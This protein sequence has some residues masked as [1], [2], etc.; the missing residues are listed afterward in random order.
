MK[1]A[2]ITPYLHSHASP[3]AAAGATNR[4]EQVLR[5]AS[6]Q[7]PALTLLVAPAAVP[8][9]AAETWLGKGFPPVGSWLLGNE[10][11]AKVGLIP[12]W[13]W[14]TWGWDRTNK[15]QVASWPEA[16]KASVKPPAG[17]RLVPPEEYDHPYSGLGELRIMEVESQDEVR[18]LCPWTVFPKAGAYGCTSVIPGLG[19]R[20]VLAP[21]ADMKRVGVWRALILRHEIA[22]CNGW[23]GDHRGALPIEDWAPGL[24]PTMCWIIFAPEADI[25]AFGLI[26]CIF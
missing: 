8:A 19:C 18:R 26:V 13:V 5:T 17:L 10:D 9:S 14:W 4:K 24:S 15:T 2:N 6:I 11:P 23:P 7:L 12:Q 16:P 22:H 1:T 3:T 20:V 21:E 25:K